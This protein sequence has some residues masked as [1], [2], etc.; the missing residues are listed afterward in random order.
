MLTVTDTGEGMSPEVQKE[1]FEPFFTTKA[2]GKSTGLG[3]STVY[4]IVKQ[5]RGHI[6]VYSEKGKGTPF[7]IYFPVVEELSEKEERREAATMPPGNE[8]ILV[9]DDDAS[10]RKFVFDTLEP[11]GYSLLAASCGE[12]AL[13]LVR[14][15]KE[16][17]DLLLSDVIMP[18][19]N[20]RDL[21]ER[22]K[23]ERPA[24]K[25][26]LM[27][28]YTD[29]VIAPSGVLEPGILFVNKPLLPRALANKLRSVLDGKDR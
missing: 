10:I 15:H 28:G 2:M 29:N 1:I 25:T 6:F 5:H 13:F 11:L 16:K 26:V 23:K 22:V 17:I 21:S 4:G 8:T 12:E 27:S 14:S 24:I 7:K 20:G 9:V 18:G 3:L 19:M